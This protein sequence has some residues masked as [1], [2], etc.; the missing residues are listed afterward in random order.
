MSLPIKVIF[1][2][3]LLENQSFVESMYKFVGESE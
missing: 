2:P 1:E 3:N